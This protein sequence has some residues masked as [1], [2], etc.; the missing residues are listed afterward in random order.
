M[1]LF[2]PMLYKFHKL[3]LEDGSGDLGSKFK[4]FGES[5]TTLTIPSTIS[6]I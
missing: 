2:D 4:F 1:G 5:K 6:S 3:E